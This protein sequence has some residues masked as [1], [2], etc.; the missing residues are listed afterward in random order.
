MGAVV[1]AST[2]IDD[3]LV[4]AVFFANPHV[5]VGAVI[6]G[7][8]IGLAALVIV[9]AAFALLTLAVPAEWIALLGLLP[10]FLGLRLLPGLF[11]HYGDD[12]AQDPS[13]TK[14]VAGFGAQAVSVAVVT[15]ANGG[16]NLGVYIPLF[17]SA[18]FA[19]ATYIAVFSVLTALWC[20]LGYW[21]VNNP[22]VR[23]EIRCYGHV[24]LPLVLTLLGLYILSGALPL[25]S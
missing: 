12:S 5:R 25:L 16:D 2:N 18:P 17:A 22:L 7:R 4:L 8:F 11:R 10:L 9:S 15:L 21:V 6:S 14:A 19:I 1:Y 24:L 13:I 3:L 20:L 23:G